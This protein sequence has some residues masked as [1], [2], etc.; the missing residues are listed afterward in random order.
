MKIIKFRQ[1]NILI[2]ISLLLIV[3]FGQAQTTLPYTTSGS[4]VAPAGVSTIQVEAYGAGGG[5]GC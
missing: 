1:K 4:F 5:G 2:I 3:C